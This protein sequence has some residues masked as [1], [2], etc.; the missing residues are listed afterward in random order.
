M[1]TYDQ[2]SATTAGGANCID[3]HSSFNQ[4]GQINQSTF[5]AGVS[6]IFFAIKQLF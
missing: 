1:E 6:H 3:C 4:N 5:V 2:G